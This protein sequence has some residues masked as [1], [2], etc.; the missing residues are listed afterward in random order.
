M[1]TLTNDEVG[2]KTVV[3]D[4]PGLAYLAF[5]KQSIRHDPLRC[6]I[7]SPTKTTGEGTG[8]GLSISY[9]A[10]TQQHGGT[11]TV[12]SEPGL[13]NSRCVCPAISKP[14]D[15]ERHERRYSRSR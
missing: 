3:P 12:E 4:L 8:L 7:S 11:I 9:D 2:W 5:E 14:P 1:I 13:P 6:G 10:V 15:W